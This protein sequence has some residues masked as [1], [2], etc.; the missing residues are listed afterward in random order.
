[1]HLSRG[2]FYPRPSSTT[3]EFEEVVGL[4]SCVGVV[5]GSEVLLERG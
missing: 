1:M 4:G 2:R 5:V 3:A